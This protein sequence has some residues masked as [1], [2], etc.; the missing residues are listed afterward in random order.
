MLRKIAPIMSDSELKLP[1]LLEWT[2]GFEPE[3]EEDIT[4]YV[5]TSMPFDLKPEEAREA[6][7]EWMRMT[8]TSR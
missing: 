4:T 1:R 2:G 8:T 3:T 5:E 6:L 7:R